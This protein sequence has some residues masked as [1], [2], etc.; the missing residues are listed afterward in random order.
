MAFVN[1]AEKAHPDAE[2]MTTHYWS[3]GEL[4]TLLLQSD[5]LVKREA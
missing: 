3:D 1:H 2:N 4:A 5:P